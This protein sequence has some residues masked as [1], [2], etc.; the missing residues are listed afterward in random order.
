MKRYWVQVLAFVLVIMIGLTGCSNASTMTG[1]YS[2]DTLSL[3]SSLQTAIEL[4]EGTP[5]KAEAQAQA[6]QAINEFAALYRR[7]Q[8]VAGLSSF[9][10]M[11]T[12]L[13]GLASHYSSYPNRPL[14]EKLKARLAR[15]FKQVEISL[16]R[17]S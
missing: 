2:Q 6:R 3:I 10:T 9:T 5:E 15:E 7:D 16:R 13:N 8:N 1:N 14:P 12:A 4:P 17:E 11:Q